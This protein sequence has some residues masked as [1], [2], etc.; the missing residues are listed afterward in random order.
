MG[1]GLECWS[2]TLRTSELHPEICEPQPSHLSLTDRSLDYRTRLSFDP[3]AELMDSN[4]NPF[5]NTHNINNPMRYE[6]GHVVVRM[7]EFYL[8]SNGNNIL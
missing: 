1:L 7:S 4:D 6:P 8:C 2:W 5:H 3:S